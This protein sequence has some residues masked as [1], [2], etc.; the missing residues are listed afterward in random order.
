MQ[1]SLQFITHKTH[2]LER[3]L[4]Q[5]NIYYHNTLTVSAMPLYCRNS[6]GS[7]LVCHSKLRLCLSKHGYIQNSTLHILFLLHIYTTKSLRCFMFLKEVSYAHQG[8]IY[9]TKYSIYLKHYKY[10]YCHFWPIE[11]VWIN[12]LVSSPIP[13][14]WTIVYTV[15]GIYILCV[16]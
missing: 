12:V 7:M 13:N 10:L 8:C 14:F 9:L 4:I 2:T 5:N 15:S 11:C 3:W 6:E 1:M 16:E